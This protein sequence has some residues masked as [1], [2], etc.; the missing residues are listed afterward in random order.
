MS[1]H[2]V[3]GLAT[4]Q[5]RNEID[6]TAEASHVLTWIAVTTWLASGV[7]SSLALLVQLA[8]LCRILIRQSCVL[9]AEQPTAVHTVIYTPSANKKH[10]TSQVLQIW[11]SRMLCHERKRCLTC[12]HQAPSNKSPKYFRRLERTR[13]TR[14]RRD[15]GTLA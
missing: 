10:F 13:M 4:I 12:A 15:A 6:N 2:P 11:P 9:L 1:A 5:G 8:D 3:V 7:F 14:L